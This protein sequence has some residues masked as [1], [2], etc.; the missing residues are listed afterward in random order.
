M[1][2]PVAALAGATGF[3]GGRL[4]RLLLARGWRVRALARRPA[5]K[6]AL[7]SEG[8]ETILGDLDNVEALARL[9]DGAA[10]TVNCAGLI[11]ARDRASF[12]AVNRDG[13]ARMAAATSGRH[14][15]VSSLAAREPGLSDYAASK[16]AGEEA[17]RA[18]AGGR[19]AI[20]RPPVIYGPGDRE[21][22][23]LFRM[24]GRSPLAPIPGQ[25]AA[26]LVLAHVDDVA[27]A[28][29]DLMERPDLDGVYAVGGD[30][31][32]GYAWREIMAAA[33]AAMGRAPRFARLPSWSVWAAARLSET[34]APF[35][36]APPIFTRGK[37]R[38]MLHVDWAVHAG[39]LA[40]G[41]PT[42]GYSL[43]AGFADAVRWYRHAGWL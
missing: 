19:L 26:R 14:V 2:G 21:T 40:P 15:L 3:L 25:P 30:R 35:R 18:A 13:A 9:V 38:E 32:A 16:R 23:A 27:E 4:A 33:W 31:P 24:A 37:A 1:S 34:A 22:L 29:V 28:I 17:A 11:K 20:V 42:A 7:S 6:T 43:E 41:G 8:C 12:F 36:G 10:V 39:E 5:G